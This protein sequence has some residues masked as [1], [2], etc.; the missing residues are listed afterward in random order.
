MCIVSEPNKYSDVKSYFFPQSFPEYF[1]RGRKKDEGWLFFLLHVVQNTMS[2]SFRS[3]HFAKEG[4]V[5]KNLIC[6]ATNTP[7]ETQ[8]TGCEHYLS[9][10]I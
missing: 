4:F 10:A 9:W 8:V 7:R 1:L 6:E 2:L 3:G 5:N